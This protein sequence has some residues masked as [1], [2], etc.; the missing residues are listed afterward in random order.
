MD[1]ELIENRAGQ[2]RCGIWVKSQSELFNSPNA[3]REAECD[4]DS[5]NFETD[6]EFDSVSE[7]GGKKRRLATQLKA[8]I[9]HLICEWK[10]C[11][12]RTGSIDKF[13]RHVAS[14]V[15]DLPIKRLDCGQHVYACAWKN[16]IYENGNSDEILRHVNY[17]SFHTKLKCI[18]ANNR[19]R[20]KLPVSNASFCLI[21]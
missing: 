9:L 15:P 16:C 21:L 11:I 1:S 14:H 7:C 10:E 18:G 8:E 19:S 3:K 20:V 4:L 2:E 6:S 17:H 5:N 12:Y 13:I